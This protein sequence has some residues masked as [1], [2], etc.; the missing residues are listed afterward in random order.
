M[1]LGEQE[2]TIVIE[3]VEEP[4]PGEREVPPQEPQPVEAT[5]L[6]VPDRELVPA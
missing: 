1:D 5:P 6:E 2:K 3:P 4:V